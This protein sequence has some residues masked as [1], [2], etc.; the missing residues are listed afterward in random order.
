MLTPARLDVSPR[1]RKGTGKKCGASYIARHLEC[2]NGKPESSISPR[3]LKVAAVVAGT[4]AGGALAGYAWSK[5]WEQ[6][7]GEARRLF[8]RG[9]KPDPEAAELARRRARGCRRDAASI[10]IRQDIARLPSNLIRAA[11]AETRE[12]AVQGIIPRTSGKCEAAT[13]LG[14]PSASAQVYLHTNSRTVFKVPNEVLE[15]REAKGTFTSIASRRG[16][17][18][19]EHEA[20]V[21][22]QAQAAGVPVPQLRA[23]NRR[24]G[25]IAMEYLDDYQPLRDILLSTSRMPKD[26]YHIIASNF[27]RAMEKAHMA[28]IVHRDLHPGNIYVAKGGS[29]VRVI[30]WGEGYSKLH[31]HPLAGK[32]STTSEHTVGLG[33][34]MDMVVRRSWRPFSGSEQEALNWLSMRHKGLYTKVNK[35]DTMTLEEIQNKM[36]AWYRDVDRLIDWKRRHPDQLV[37]LNQSLL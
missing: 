14:E 13:A 6:R 27:R 30:D 37:P 35:G 18:K 31:Q 28:G 25:V 34:D 22:A 17:M 24:T 15:Q 10:S 29:Q 21:H 7:Q 8:P 16:R 20:L 26:Q 5:T 2:H 4:I 33:I 12:L 32:A 19:A 9:R 3:R 11:L 36:P 23:F 1:G